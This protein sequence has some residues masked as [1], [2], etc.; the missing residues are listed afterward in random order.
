[1]NNPNLSISLTDVSN[2]SSANTSVSSRVPTPHVPPLPSSPIEPP[3]RTQPKRA[4]SLGGAAQTQPK[5]IL[6]KN[7]GKKRSSLPAAG[8]P[9]G[10]DED[11][12]EGK[13]GKKKSRR[14]KKGGK[15]VAFG[16]PQGN[17]STLL[18][19]AVNSSP[20]LLS[21]ASFDTVEADTTVELEGDDAPAPMD[22]DG[23]N[24]GMNDDDCMEETLD[25]AGGGADN[26]PKVQRS[27]ILERGPRGGII[28]RGIDLLTEDCL[29]QC[30]TDQELS[31]GT[32]RS[33]GGTAQQLKLGGL[34]YDK[35]FLACPMTTKISPR[36]RIAAEQLG[37][38]IRQIDFNGDAVS[39]SRSDLQTQYPTIDMAT[40][41]Q[42]EQI[43]ALKS[44]IKE[45]HNHVSIQAPPGVG[46]TL[47]A[48]MFLAEQGE[49]ITALLLTKE[50]AV[51]DQHQAELLATREVDKRRCSVVVRTHA[52]LDQFGDLSAA[53]NADKYNLIIVDEG[54][55]FDNILNKRRGYLERIL[56]DG[57]VVVRQSALFVTDPKDKLYPPPCCIIPFERAVEE[58]RI[59]DLTIGLI[60]GMLEDI[61]D[62]E[63][64]DEVDIKDEESSDE[65]SSDEESS[66]VEKISDS[67]NDGID[68]NATSS[69]AVP[70]S[71]RRVRISSVLLVAKLLLHSIVE[72]DE[73]R[74]GDACVGE[75]SF[76]YFNSIRD[77][78]RCYDTFV[79]KAG[80]EAA[81]ILFSGE[82]DGRSSDKVSI[83]DLETD[84]TI[85]V[86][87]AVGMFNE[88]VSV[89]R[90]SDV[91]IADPR[92]STKN[93]YQ[94]AGR[95]MRTAEGKETARLW[96]S[97][98]YNAEDAKALAPLL[99]SLLD[100]PMG[101]GVSKALKAAR[102]VAKYDKGGQEVDDEGGQEVG[103]AEQRQGRSAPTKDDRCNARN[104]IVASPPAT[105]VEGTVT[106]IELISRSLLVDR[107]TSTSDQRIKRDV[108]RAKCVLETFK[109]TMPLS[110]KNRSYKPS[111]YSYTYN[112]NVV[113]ESFDAN[114]WIRTVR[115]NS[116][117]DVHESVLELLRP[118]HGWD[119]SKEQLK[120][121]KELAR[122][123]FVVNTFKGKNKPLKG[124]K[125]EYSYTFNGTDNTETIVFCSWLN[126][127]R[128]DSKD[129]SKVD[130]WVRDGVLNP[131]LK[132]DGWTSTRK[133]SV[134]VGDEEMLTRLARR[135][136][137]PTN[138]TKTGYDKHES[139]EYKFWRKIRNG[140][141]DVPPNHLLRSVEWTFHERRSSSGAVHKVEKMWE[142]IDKARKEY[143]AEQ[144]KA[145]NEK[146]KAKAAKKKEKERKKP[147]P[148]P[149]EQER[150]N[151]GPKPKADGEG[152]KKGTK[153]TTKRGNKTSP[154]KGGEKEGDVKKVG[155][156]GRK[157]ED[158]EIKKKRRI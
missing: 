43:E 63:T 61:K 148:K 94:L 153:E 4:A 64:V 49:D 139:A 156:R 87:F 142:Q 54:H 93:V 129:P 23:D 41:C 102:K 92:F 101:D 126:K 42:N 140:K 136:D 116:D 60:T 85:R 45:G 28:D 72:P 9:M 114:K 29:I 48:R 56:A 21:S 51:V 147:G 150:K 97:P 131:L 98:I 108:A 91:I 25:G 90:C 82:V 40:E 130:E 132:W 123:Q 19:N 1:F 79:A 81:K 137:I 141:K 26:L 127:L 75:L 53:T 133:R 158:K 2:A 112:D 107:G 106:S 99:Q 120:K 80:K 38:T 18:A 155:K 50:T 47:V 35:F 110:N 111:K 125:Y 151:P 86:V 117:K 37:V 70:P 69:S 30:K 7:E 6:N 11:T 27:G 22:E 113:K 65:G 8:K 96:L 32:I 34:V 149:K 89:R 118:W 146:E 145:A 104:V 14:R 24:F 62:E 144:E 31:M 59:L 46:K 3:K 84:C 115:R 36:G 67:G 73:A 55:A 95:A 77:A 76:V 152:L 157:G 121:A 109:D 143:C 20:T 66:D 154:K 71:T 10:D 13:G 39:S 44:V 74:F 58:G 78:I 57:A 33:V 68:G 83:K 12:K 5:G 17:I 103:D 135:K 138:T 52:W 88:G 128:K 134:P 105:V 124:Q 100:S 15:S 119:T 16:S 122:A